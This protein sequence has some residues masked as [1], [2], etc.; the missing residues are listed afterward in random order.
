MDGQGPKA[1][2]G[3]WRQ[4]SLRFWLVL[5]EALYPLCLLSLWNIFFFLSS[6]AS[7]QT[8]TTAL[9]F[10]VSNGQDETQVSTGPNKQLLHHEVQNALQ[11]T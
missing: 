3:L 4:S 2:A 8:L 7:G 9:G 11:N 1:V 5:A 6:R 10:Q